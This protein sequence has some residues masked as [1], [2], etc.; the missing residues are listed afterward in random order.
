MYNEVHSVL[1]EENIRILTEHRKQHQAIIQGIDEE[2]R[3]LSTELEGYKQNLQECGIALW[4]ESAKKRK[5][6]TT[7]ITET[8]RKLQ[9]RKNVRISATLAYNKVPLRPI[10]YYAS[11]GHNIKLYP[12][13]GLDATFAIEY[14]GEILIY[15]ACELSLANRTVD[16]NVDASEL[17]KAIMTGIAGGAFAGFIA[18]SL[19]QTHAVIYEISLTLLNKEDNSL[20]K[21]MFAQNARLTSQE[22][23]RFAMD[24]S[25][26]IDSFSSMM[27]GISQCEIDTH[28]LL[29]KQHTEKSSGSS[30]PPGPP[31]VRTSAMKEN[32]VAHK[33]ITVASI[34]F[35]VGHSQTNNNKIWDLQCNF[36]YRGEKIARKFSMYISAYDKDA[37]DYT[38][39]RVFIY[40][41]NF[42]SNCDYSKTWTPCWT[43]K[44]IDHIKIL[45][46][47]TYFIDGTV[48][49]FE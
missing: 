28:Y 40:E 5:H 4:G 46:I 17:D 42:V 2:I 24:Y 20:K 49:E 29:Q 48:Q 45:K 38:P 30:K 21:L 33:D 44:K 11:L 39:H 16:A 35:A 26:F 1:S 12:T 27:S 18:T 36:Q 34:N 47:K 6:I 41:G 9:E 3:R 8:E 22:Y 23:H 13:N 31:G 19:A 7:L 32:V 10:G 25:R 43:G 37:N 15:N 14:D